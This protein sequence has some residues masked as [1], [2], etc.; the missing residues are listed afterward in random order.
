MIQCKTKVIGAGNT[1]TAV[2]LM[3]GPYFLKVNG[4][5]NF[6]VDRRKT[7]KPECNIK[8]A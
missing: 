5:L 1:V 6:N 7:G 4:P 2:F 8:A 3:A